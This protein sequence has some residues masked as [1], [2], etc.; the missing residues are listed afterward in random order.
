M[1]NLIDSFIR[2]AV[3]LVRHNKLDS[4]C[5]FPLRF[6]AEKLKIGGLGYAVIRRYCWFHENTQQEVLL[7]WWIINLAS[8]QMYERILLKAQAKEEVADLTSCMM[9]VY[10]A[11]YIFW[12]LASA[13]IMGGLQRCSGISAASTK[14]SPILP[15]GGIQVGAPGNAPIAWISGCGIIAHQIL[16]N[17]ASQNPV[18]WK[19]APNP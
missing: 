1:S 13:E 5:R 10:P 19:S 17:C 7:S 8:L 11:P 3:H 12:Q 9:Y 4:N 15:F 2:S 6:W 18:R 16:N 14:C